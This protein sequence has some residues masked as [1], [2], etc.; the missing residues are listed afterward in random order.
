MMREL[1]NLNP[2]FRT[3]EKIQNIKT[4]EWLKLALRK[5]NSKLEKLAKNLCINKSLVTKNLLWTILVKK[6]KWWT[7]FS[8]RQPH[9]PTTIQTDN[10]TDRQ[11]YKPTT[12]QTNRQPYKQTT[13]KT[14]NHTFKTNKVEILFHNRISWNP[15]NWVISLTTHWFHP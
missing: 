9:K 15:L 5:K 11:P 1:L 3:F 13:I 2:I 6:T 7:G 8:N 12:I 14:D 4:W 10:H